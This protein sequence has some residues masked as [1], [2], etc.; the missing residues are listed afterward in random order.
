LAPRTDPIGPSEDVAPLRRGVRLSSTPSGTPRATP[1]PKA[2]RRHSQT[3]TPLPACPLNSCVF[4]V[5]FGKPPSDHGTGKAMRPKEAKDVEKLERDPGPPTPKGLHSCVAWNHDGHPRA[6]T[7]GRNPED[8][9]P[10]RRGVRLSSTPSGPPRATSQ[11]PPRRNRRHA[12][13]TPKPERL[14]RLAP[15]TPASFAFLSGAAMGSVP[16]L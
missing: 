7:E 2:C 5:P 12:I 15:S 16:Y 4:C 1:E 11:R 14:C 9:A 6:T 10:L 8:V 13:A 3:R